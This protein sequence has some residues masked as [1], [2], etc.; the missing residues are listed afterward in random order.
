MDDKK[1]VAAIAAVMSILTSEEK[2]SS[3]QKLPSRLPSAWANYG[4]QQTMN[5]RTLYQRRLAKR[6]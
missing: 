1:K 6:V 5:F 3:E 2:T 4:R